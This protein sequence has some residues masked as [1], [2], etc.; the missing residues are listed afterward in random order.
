MFTRRAL[1]RAV[2]PVPMLLVVLGCATA[3]PGPTG[4]VNVATLE[5][6]STAQLLDD[7]VARIALLPLGTAVRQQVVGRE[8]AART[9]EYLAAM[10][11]AQPRD[12]VYGLYVAFDQMNWR[13]PRSMPW[14]DRR[15]WPK[16]ASLEYDFHDA[17]QDWYAGAKSSGKLHITEPYFDDGGSNVTMVSVTR[18]VND[19][20]G[21]FFA[22]AGA[23]ISL[24]DIQRHLKSSVGEMYLVSR[25]GRVIAHPK[26]ELRARKGYAGEDLRNLPGG[27]AIAA[28][29]SGSTFV[30]VGATSRTM[31]WTTAPLTGWRVVVS[32]P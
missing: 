14:V 10:L 2:R 13:D 32:V 8:P 1:W 24:E 15:S 27:A 3:E 16:P 4:R 29:P 9:I 12:D 25:S 11:D 23:D 28:A 18:P 26:A 31:V 21:R 30:T 20:A 5:A 17:R 7:W 6:R 19:A 22:V